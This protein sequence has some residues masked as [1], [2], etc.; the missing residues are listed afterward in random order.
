MSLR[1]GSLAMVLLGGLGFVGLLVMTIW[2]S[3]MVPRVTDSP[4]VLRPSSGSADVDAA[5]TI[6]LYAYAETDELSSEN[7]ETLLEAEAECH[8]AR[9][10]L[11]PARGAGPAAW[12]SECS[13]VV[14]AI[15][16]PAPAAD[17][18]LERFQRA[19]T[20]ADAALPLP[21][22][23]SLQSR[24]RIVR[25]ENVGFDFAAWAEA[26]VEAAAWLSP[27]GVS[28]VLPQ[29]FRSCALQ[30]DASS[31]RAR[32]LHSALDA[33]IASGAV[34]SDPDGGGQGRRGIVMINSS[35]RGPFR[36]PSDDAEV[37]PTEWTAT[38][39]QRLGAGAGDSDNRP[40]VGI[41]ASTLACGSP[42]TIGPHA[43]TGAWA[44]SLPAMRV[45]IDDSIA[46]TSMHVNMDAAVRDGE[47]AASRAVLRS[48][49]NLASLLR[50]YYD[51]D[52]RR[53]ATRRCNGLRNPWVR[54]HMY[55][56]A[57]LSVHA[58]EAM[59]IKVRAADPDS[60]SS[61]ARHGRVNDR[62]AMAWARAAT[63]WMAVQRDVRRA[64]ML[65]SMAASGQGL[66]T[67]PAGLSRLA[68]VER[69]AVDKWDQVVNA[70]PIE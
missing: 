24:I 54:P 41:V 55:D 10:L 30:D 17:R 52:F 9:V 48:G 14:V 4:R 53:E 38:F 42:A 22:V 35:V 32:S 62:D 60:S 28:D 64:R 69:L 19:A 45:I 58:L 50:K 25:R 44:A 26:L 39:L 3:L 7:L 66:P 43:Q 37:A 56:R 51:V 2:S 18:V 65:M 40:A 46:F 27:D 12:P 49:A 33:L 47:H 1:R 61:Q 11:R 59:F 34:R 68:E 8:E 13:W 15:N 16:G 57:G 36:S 20:A 6:V 67:G 23:V 21:P 63:Q 5:R 31:C 70:G 29:H